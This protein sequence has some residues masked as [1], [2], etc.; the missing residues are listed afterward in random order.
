M[1]LSQQLSRTGQH[2]CAEISTG[3]VTIAGDRAAVML[4]GE[5]R[6]VPVAC[7]GGITWTPAVGDDVLV[8]HSDEGERY[9]LGLAG[10]AGEMAPPGEIILK[11]GD[12]SLRIGRDGLEIKGTLLLNG[13]DVGA[14]LAQ[15]TL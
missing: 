14:A 12:N 7:A 10:G 1:W 8:L 9:I 4:E 5:R 13:R 15:L 2:S 11:C 6:E 3:R